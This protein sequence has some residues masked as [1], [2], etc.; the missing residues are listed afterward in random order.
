MLPLNPLMNP[1][2]FERRFQEVPQV[3]AF[4][5]VCRQHQVKPYLV[6]G[7]VR[8]LL[9]QD[10]LSKDLDVVVPVEA[11]KSIA[12]ALSEVLDAKL[13]CLD[14]QYQIY[15][16][17]IFPQIDMID[18][19]G[20]MG[21]TIEQDL[22][23][24]DLTINAIAYDFETKA[25]L[26]PL[27]G[28]DDLAHGMIR[29]VDEKNL[30]DDPLRLLRVFRIGADLGF[31]EIEPKTL[32]AVTRHGE[33]L[34]HASSERIHYELMRLFSA[35]LCYSHLRTMGKCGLL[36]TIFPELS[37]T[38]QIPANFYH[39]LGLFDH[40]LELL[41]QLEVHFQDLPQPIQGD[42]LKPI[43]PFTK[44]IALVRLACLFHDIGKPA[45]MEYDA[46]I[47][48]YKF[49]GHDLVSAEMT[50][51]IAQRL[52]WG[53]EV[54]KTI[55]QLVRWHLYPGDLIKPGITPKGYRKFFRR[56][57]PVLTELIPVAIADRFSAQGPAI[58]K[59]DLE[60]SKAG[61]IGLWH[62]YQDFLVAEQQKTNLLTGKDVIM[63]LKLE[64]GPQVGDI[65]EAV[66]EAYL[67]GE[68][69]TKDEALTW[70]KAHYATLH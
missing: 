21:E 36:E 39:H 25:I 30:L 70:I 15:R 40:T 24:R 56:L 23:R 54:T 69:N 68:L 46:E 8:D 47:Q 48:K 42:L 52:P 35:P 17:I 45:T 2:D 41:H 60:A 10:I 20:C 49:Y 16:L 53:K 29:M 37:P 58:S 57:G 44:R 38:R 19:A 61:L 9:Y 67:N 32:E 34:I 3:Q 62:Q 27:G 51:G 50:W 13:I 28:Q 22:R 4:L 6:G 59:A 7:A 55:C 66:Q 43:N 65:L 5:E 26:D 18:I 63:H 31:T 12:T 1:L 33:K 14:E 64:P 11:A